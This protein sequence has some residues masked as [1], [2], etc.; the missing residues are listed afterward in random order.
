[1]LIYTILLV[2]LIAH[3]FDNE[4]SFV[5]KE[6]LFKSVTVC[7]YDLYA[8]TYTLRV[9]E[10]Y[11]VSPHIVGVKVVSDVLICYTF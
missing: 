11:L 7:I 8:F 2:S 9:W 6:R 5:C 4:C 10:Y 1:M 3:D